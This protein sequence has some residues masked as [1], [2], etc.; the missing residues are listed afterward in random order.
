MN[1]RP[2]RPAAVLWDMDGT[3]IDSEPYWIAAEMELATR[4]GARWTHADGLTL[5]GRPLPD[6]AA[7]LQSR[8]ID[9]EVGEIVDY[10]VGRVTLQVRA[11]APW[12]RD[13]EDLLRAV[14]EAGIP[15]ALVTQ[16]YRPLVDALLA[17]VPDAFAV[18]VTGED[19]KRGKPDPEAYQLAATRLGVDV[20]H[21]VAIEDSPAGIASAR[22]AGAA[23]IGVRRL[24]AVEPQPGLSR[25]RSL[26]SVTISTL[27]AIASGSVLDELGAEV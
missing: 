20:T 24:V 8:G 4:F 23:T 5:V 10:L 26:A 14:L 22:A 21:C 19:V 11:R 13:A 6:S 7:I 1:Q 12:Q 25:V 15:C 9:M 3:L 17:R 2:A 27:Q 16:S 18:V